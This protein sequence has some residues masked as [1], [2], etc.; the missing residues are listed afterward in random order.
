MYLQS[1]QGA[2]DQH[3]NMACGAIDMNMIKNYKKNNN[4]VLEQQ[5]E[6]S[7]K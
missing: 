1:N 3:L 2:I 6:S 5:N 7:D 4:R